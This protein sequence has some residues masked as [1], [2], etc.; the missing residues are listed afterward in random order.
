MNPV[1]RLQADFA[2]TGLSIGTRPMR[3][4][5][6]QLDRMRVATAA[7]VKHLPEDARFAWR[8]WSSAASNLTPPKGSSFLVW[9]M[10]PVS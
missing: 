8:A 1:E 9:K 3:F 7:R 6:E 10:K 5:R 4:H 2:N